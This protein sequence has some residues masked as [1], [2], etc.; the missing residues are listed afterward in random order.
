MYNSDLEDSRTKEV[1]IASIESDTSNRKSVVAGEEII[2]EEQEKYNNSDKNTRKLLNKKIIIGIICILSI[3]LC[4]VIYTVFISNKNS[5]SNVNE[6]DESNLISKINETYEGLNYSMTTEVVQ[7]L[8]FFYDH[9]KNLEGN[10]IDVTYIK[11]SG[12]KDTTLEDKIND[13][14]KT[15]V[16][17]MY[18]PKYVQDNNILYD[19]IYNY[20]DV[21]VFNNVLSTMYCEEICDVDGNIKYNYKSININL[22]EFKEFKL[23][24]VF[25]KNTNIEEI[26]NTQTDLK[27]S[28]DL[29]FSVSPKNIYVVDENGKIDKVNLYNNKDKV[30]LYKRFNEN[31]KIFNKTYNATPYVFTTKRFVESDI[32]GLEEDNLF[33]DTCNLIVDSSYNEELVQVASNLYK[34]AVNKARN[35]SYANPSK[36][37]LVQIIPTIIKNE[38]VNYTIMVKYNAYEIDKKFFKDSII[39]F[40]VA[41]ENEED[42]EIFVVDYLND[43]NI[44]NASEY[45][46][47]VN[48]E[49]LNKIVDKNGNEVKDKNDINVGIS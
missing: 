6:E 10:K 26:I 36:R 16:I 13:R 40:A 44:M 20:T 23:E 4:V 39:N 22:K 19:H 5:N 29:I 2:L 48:S 27:Y 11:I 32:Y 24:D 43:S 8:G 7:Q 34:D 1:N 38:D 30:A 31:K 14:L 46:N 9:S 45:V 21:Y 41:S 33:I 47:N 15:E 18:E 17:S 37:Y 3:L 35:L 28:Q 12:L 42:K 49:I 25:I